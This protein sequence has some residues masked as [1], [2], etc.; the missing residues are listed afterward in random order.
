[1]ASNPDYA[2]Y[3]RCMEEIKRRLSAIDEIL[4]DQK[5]TSYRYTNVEFVALQF[6]KIFELVI[7][8]TL[9]SHQQFFEGLSRKLAKEW[10]VSKIVAIVEKKNRGF[11]PEPIDR[12]PT[13]KE[14]V[15]DEWKSIT[16]GFL[17]LN[18]LIEAHGKIG[19]LMHANNPYREEKS[20]T[21]ME[22]L[23]PIWR[24]RLMRLLNNHL[25]KF[26]DDATVLYVGMQSVETGAVHTALFKKQASP[27]T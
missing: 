6:R 23:F 21:E 17:T 9:A 22:G 10:Q 8:A 24:E 11:Y 4:H 1:M 25:V 16:S 13:G 26:P 12:I 3:A 14:G 18:E 15:K 27:K 5:S 19:A 20:L 7:L 2:N